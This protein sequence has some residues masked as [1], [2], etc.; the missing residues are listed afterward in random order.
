MTTA[1]TVGLP[2]ANPEGVPKMMSEGRLVGQPFAKRSSRSTPTPAS[3]L[4][5][6][7]RVTSR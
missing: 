4:D 5:Q 7:A 1:C 2:M 3:G 6:E